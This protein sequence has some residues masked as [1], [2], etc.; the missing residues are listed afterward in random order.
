[1][2]VEDL[3]VHGV[4][5]EL[6]DGDVAVGAGA[7]KQTAGFVGRPGDYV[8]GGGVQGEVEDAGP[9]V[10]LLAPDEDFAVVGRGGEDVAVLW[11]RPGDGPDCAFVSGESEGQLN[12]HLKEA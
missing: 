7:G 11:M 10:A 9:G 4:V 3:V 1:M 6:E 5:L 2:R 8:D 12:L